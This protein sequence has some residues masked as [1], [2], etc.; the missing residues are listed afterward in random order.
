LPDLSRALG[1][2]LVHA[3]HLEL[4]GLLEPHRLARPLQ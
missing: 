4:L 3:L 1:G 2:E